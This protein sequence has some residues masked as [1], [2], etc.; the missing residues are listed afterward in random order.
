MM[1]GYTL[2]Y[3]ENELRRIEQ[4]F[5][6][7]KQNADVS[8]VESL[9]GEVCNIGASSIANN[10]NIKRYVEDLM[11]QMDSYISDMRYNYD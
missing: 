9:L 6:K 7:C 5:E 3:A 8:G 1:C 4:E 11:N 10:D 2:K